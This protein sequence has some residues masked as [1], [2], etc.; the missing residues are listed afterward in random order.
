MKIF[1]INCV[2]M[3]DKE[4]IVYKDR[5]GKVAGHNPTA[6]KGMF[7]RIGD[8]FAGRPEPDGPAAVAEWYARGFTPF[9]PNGDELPQSMA[10]RPSYVIGIAGE[11]AASKTSVL[12]S[13]VS[14]IQSDRHLTKDW[15]VSMTGESA[16]AWR[17]QVHR[18]FVDREPVDASE[19]RSE[20]ERPDAVLEEEEPQHA[21]ASK[22]PL[23][24]L[25]LTVARKDGRSVNLVLVDVAG[26]ST[27]N[28]TAVGG[29]S[30]HLTKANQFWFFVTP[31]TSGIVRDELAAQPGIV[32]GQQQNEFNQS[33]FMTQQMI[34]HA[35][36]IWKQANNYRED[37]RVGAPRLK[38]IAVLSKA[39]QLSGLKNLEPN[40]QD[41]IDRIAPPLDWLHTDKCDA[42]VYTNA[43]SADTRLV[44]EELLGMVSN[45]ITQH[46]HEPV[47]LPVAATGCAAR[48]DPTP[49][50]PDRWGY[51]KVK[52]YGV[53]DLFVEAISDIPELKGE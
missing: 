7:A 24:P 9:C 22:E 44:F 2:Q 38:T 43:R 15:L 46:F 14:Q 27:V 23:K 13:M 49:A 10:D 41:A 53:V 12:V 3:F 48:P 11:T 50:D 20:R 40:L 16:S 1:C 33:T 36:Q 34:L 31:A 17:A 19:L 42:D 35:A 8:V 39:D 32:D 25:V 18:Q 47:F 6:R 37:E 45:A 5:N 51:E 52:P 4:Q 26:E 21:W 28:V 30:P 29:L